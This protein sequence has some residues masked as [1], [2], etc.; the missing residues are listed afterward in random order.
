MKYE[1]NLQKKPAYSW[2]SQ[3]L[4]SWI[5]QCVAKESTSF[6]VQSK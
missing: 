3:G 4:V 6:K 1:L 5:L 2:H